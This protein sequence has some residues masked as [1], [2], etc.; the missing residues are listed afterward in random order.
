MSTAKD[1]MSHLAIKNITG[2]GTQYQMPFSQLRPSNPNNFFYLPQ[3][4]AS[5]YPSV[6]GQS[7][8]SPDLMI[9]GPAKASWFTAL[10]LNAWI[11]TVDANA[12]SAFHSFGI[13]NPTSTVYRVFDQFKCDRLDISGNAAGGPQ[14]VSSSW[15]GLFGDSELGGTAI[16]GF[17][18]TSFSATSVV[19]SAGQLVNVS[20]VSVAGATLVRSYN[21]TLNRGQTVQRYFTN[22]AYGSDVSSSMASGQL[23]L[24]QEPSGTSPTSTVAITIGAVT[25]TLLLNLDVFSRGLQTGYGT[26][27]NTYSMIDVTAGGSNFT[28]A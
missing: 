3:V 15:A 9:M 28:I 12:D 19:P 1:F 24:E 16:N 25:F 21:M 13:Y 23:T 11:G 7:Q 10:N 27:I 17:S 6:Y 8:K 4:N 20:G 14:N 18:Q 26:K 22:N 5:A 2:A